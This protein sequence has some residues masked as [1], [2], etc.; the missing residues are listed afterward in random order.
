MVFPAVYTTCPD[1]SW[2]VLTIISWLI[3]NEI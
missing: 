3:V 1:V 2:R